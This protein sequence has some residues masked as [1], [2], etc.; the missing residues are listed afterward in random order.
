MKITRKTITASAE[1]YNRDTDRY[2]N[3]YVVEGYY[4]KNYS[5]LAHSMSTN[6][7]SEAVDAAHAYL[8]DGDYV[9]MSNTKSGK[10][11]RIDPD[12]YFENFDGEFIIGPQELE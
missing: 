12:E 3:T 4:G 8:S 6:D 9:E 10:V 7:W 2:D 1:D 11:V 5:G